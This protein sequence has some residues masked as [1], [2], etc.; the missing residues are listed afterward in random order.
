[1][2]WIQQSDPDP[3]KCRRSATLIQSTAISSIFNYFPN[4]YLNLNDGSFPLGKLNFNMEFAKVAP[5]NLKVIYEV[6]GSDIILARIRNAAS[7]FWRGHHEF[8]D[9]KILF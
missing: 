8:R 7:K 3:A 1:M 5:L 2:I 6:R 4:K 9:K